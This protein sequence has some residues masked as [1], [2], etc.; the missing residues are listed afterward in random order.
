MSKTHDET[1]ANVLKSFQDDGIGG[2]WKFVDTFFSFLGR[3][4]NLLS[5]N[6]AVKR[7]QGI[8]LKHVEQ[9]QR[10]DAKR[11]KLEKQEKQ[12]KAKKAAEAKEPAKATPNTFDTEKVE[13]KEEK[14]VETVGLEEGEEGPAGN[15]GKTDKYTWTQTLSEAVVMFD[16]PNT[17]R[18]KDLNVDIDVQSL[19][20]Q[21]KGQDPIVSGELN[22]KCDSDEATWTIETERGKDTKTL[23]LYLPKFNKMGWWKTVM[24]GDKEIDTK[25]IVPE[26]SKLE[27]LDGDTRSTVEKMMYDQRQKKM[28][29]PTS[30]EQK[31]QDALSKFMSMHP[32]MDFSKAKIS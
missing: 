12:E 30:D 27:D 20:V 24:K 19:H 10:D 17:L 23:T 9:A 25:K 31:K 26:N 13:A 14:K 28:G 16:I 8:A 3:K 32:E 29:K 6:D 2:E 15:G 4:T 21:I 11:R 7:I 22:E 5:N 1:L 18:G